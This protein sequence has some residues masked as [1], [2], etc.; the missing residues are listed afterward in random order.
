MSADATRHKV[1]LLF[2]HF[3]IE[4]G[5]ILFGGFVLVL[6]GVLD[7]CDY[8]V[9]VC[10]SDSS[11]EALQFYFQRELCRCSNPCYLPIQSNIIKLGVLGLQNNKRREIQN[12]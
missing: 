8:F 1:L 6:C 11:E 7:M 12:A 3:S 5:F 9:V 4:P 10:F 2:K